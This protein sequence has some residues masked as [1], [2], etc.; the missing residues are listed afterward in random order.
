MKVVEERI[1]R[2]PVDEIRAILKEQYRVDL[3]GVEPYLDGDS[4]AFTLP[5]VAETTSDLS[6]TERLDLT[7]LDRIERKAVRRKL[8][9][10]SG[11]TIEPSVRRKKARRRRRRRNRIKTRGWPVVAR[12]TNSKG[13]VANVYEPLVKALESREVTHSEQK[14]IVRQLMVENGNDPSPES[15]EYFLQNTL[16]YLRTRT[17]PVEQTA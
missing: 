17:K 12:I 2:V 14:R 7:G 13:L 16:E 5:I 4:L 8:N 1:I 15:V 11:A 6:R 9:E 3:T 10:F